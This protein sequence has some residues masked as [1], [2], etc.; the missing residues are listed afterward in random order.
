MF[1]ISQISQNEKLKNCIFQLALILPSTWYIACAE[2]WDNY[3]EICRKS[4]PSQNMSQE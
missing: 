4:D 3:S 2:C 1:N